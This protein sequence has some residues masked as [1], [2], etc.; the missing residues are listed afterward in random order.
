MLEATRS[1]D[2]KANN[3]SPDC[4]VAKGAGNGRGALK[5]APPENS[6]SNKHP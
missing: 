3:A 2:A 5:M 6:R 4:R 1:I